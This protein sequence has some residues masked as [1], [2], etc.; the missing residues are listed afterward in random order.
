MQFSLMIILSWDPGIEASVA[1]LDQQRLDTY[2]EKLK[3]F[4]CLDKHL[5]VIQH[6]R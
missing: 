6:I 2:P 1:L 5:F 4:V 3:L